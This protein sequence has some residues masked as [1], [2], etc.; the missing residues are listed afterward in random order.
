MLLSHRTTTSGRSGRS[1][2]HT[3]RPA[4]L[5]VR[6]HYPAAVLECVVNL[7][8]GRSPDILGALIRSGGTALLD[9]HTDPDHHRSVFTLV[10]REP[11]E[12]EAAV[13]RLATVA[14]E[15]LSLEDHE[16]VHP[17][18]GVI[19][20][21]PFVALDPTSIQTAV[22]A[23][24]AFAQWIG[25]ELAIPAF[26][27]DRADPAG[28]DLPSVRRDAFAPRAVGA[29]AV[30]V[31]VNVELAGDDMDLARA[32]ASEVRERDGGRRGVRALG[33]ALPSVGR[34][35]VS[36][37]LVDLD[38]T[39]LEVA[40]VDVRTRV[41][42]RGGAVRRI[43]LVGLVPA[44][45]LDACS[46]EF[47]EWSGLGTDDTIEARLARTRDGRAAGD[48]GSAGATPGAGPVPLA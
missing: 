45:V 2:I 23:A 34:S 47:L 8:E 21:V 10:G 43:E 33:L 17:R 35:Q 30:L 13:R 19:D 44:A 29:R 18:L 6:H 1:G 42:S 27:Y 14:A 39:G 48:G 26:L 24:R 20:V 7:S 37:N 32:V 12:T 25:T 15:T 5:V 9:V 31:A 46:A 38:H 28:R 16:G 40:C 3:A 11:D 4:L 36:M 41:E 22:D